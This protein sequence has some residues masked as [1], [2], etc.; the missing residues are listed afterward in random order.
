MTRP[1]TF[2]SALMLAAIAFADDNPAVES[3]GGAFSQGSFDFN[4]RLR[5]ER[6]GEDA[7]DE[8][9][10][11]STLRSRITWASA[12]MNGWQL[13]LE[14][15]NV[16]AV[17]ADQFNSTANDKGQYPV[18]ADP[19]GSEI[20]RAQLSWQ[21]PGAKATLGRQRINHGD[22]RMLGGVGWRQNE[23]TFDA[24]RAE[25]ELSEKFSA[26]YG[27]IWNVNRIFGPTGDNADLEGDVHSLRLSYAAAP[28]HQLTFYHYS[29]DFDDA[30][31]LS[32]RTSGAHYQGEGGPLTWQLAA[33]LQSD[34]GDNTA[35]Y[36][37][38]YYLAELA[39]KPFAGD[40]KIQLAAGSERLGA[41]GDGR[42]ITP[43][44]TL[45]KFQGFADKFLNTPADG[46]RDHYARAGA[47]LAG[48]KL[49]DIKVTASYHL[50]RADRGGADYGRELDLSASYAITEK[51]GLLAK[52]ARYRADQWGSDT[53]KFW[54]QL[55]VDF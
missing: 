54:L 16:S 3:L 38:G 10:K 2:L 23:Q 30:P 53:N 49:A 20:N 40:Y 7:F 51:I 31:A 48:T 41:D 9:A 11:A 33:A 12:P 36:R 42:F 24:A 28:G 13:L 29:M 52:A 35:D 17:G 27:Y 32:N 1:L 18:V 22:Q 4:F 8:D 39:G 34:Y 37:A 46:L 47:S 15:D 44:A 5:H 14:A 26:D 6:V 43:L 55:N 25:V 45:H 19:K 50:Y 21:A